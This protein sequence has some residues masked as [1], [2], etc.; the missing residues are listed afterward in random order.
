MKNKINVLSVRVFGI[1]VF[2]AVFTF[3]AATC[4]GQSGGG[5]K[6]INSLEELK[7]Y[8]DSQPANSQDKPIKVSMAANEPML[9]K[10]SEVL[11]SAGKYVSL[12]LTGNILKTIPD[13]AFLDMVASKGCETLVGITIPDNV[14]SI[15]RAA[16]YG[17]TKLASVII[18]NRVTTIEDQVFEGCTSLTSVI[19]PSSVTR[20]E[21]RVFFECT[22]LTSVTI[23]NSVTRIGEYAFICTSLAS[24]TFQGTISSLHIRAFYAGL[25][26]K[27]LAE[28]IGTYTTT[29]PVNGNS[30]WKKQ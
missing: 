19:I 25:S 3:S 15:G 26:E 18:P 2:I 9:P 17:C 16:F 7:K 30:K 11:N 20:I 13:G 12:N 24:V 28:G 21:D 23:P 4:S 14:T 29:A 27:Y 10:I 5:G 1:I 22:S 6:T 8:L